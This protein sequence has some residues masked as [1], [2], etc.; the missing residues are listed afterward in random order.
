MEYKLAGI[1]QV[2]INPRAGLSFANG[3]RSIL[4]QDPDIIMVGEIRDSETAQ[5]SIRAAI[6][7]HLVLSTLHT[8]DSPSSIVRL[9]DMGVEPYLVSSAVIGVV[10]QR[11]VKELCPFCKVPYEANISEKYL[12]GVNGN[13]SITLYKPKGCNKCNNGFIGRRAVHE[14]MVINEEMRKLINKEAN[15]DELRICAKKS[16]MTTLLNNS[17]ELA[18]EGISTLEE[19][20]K[21]GFTLG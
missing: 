21:A 11:L 12:L 4:R 7:G 2:Q 15:I 16:G 5:I 18:L 17:L 1:N 8:N 19:S 6:T 3:L 14:I 13:Y 20:L 10:S 9:L